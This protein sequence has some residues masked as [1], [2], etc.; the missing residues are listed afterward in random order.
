MSRG[1]LVAI[2]GIDG[3][4]KTTLI[5]NLKNIINERPEYKKYK[6]DVIFTK[7]P[8]NYN[9]IKQKLKTETN[10]A[11]ILNMFID[12]YLIHLNELIYP[13]LNSGK[14]VITDRYIESRIAYQSAMMCKDIHKLDET[15]DF[16]KNKHPIIVEPDLTIL[17]RA[18]PITIKNRLSGRKQDSSDIENKVDMKFVENVYL[19]LLE[20][21]PDKHFVMWTDGCARCI[22][23]RIMKKLSTDIFSKI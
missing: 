21:K 9:D 10:P 2:E 4:G 7:E 11:I 20:S 8:Y 13:A 23:N 5:S 6:N 1:L 19:K 17:L 14:I 16:I 3:T 15:I 18:Q 12:D 22:S